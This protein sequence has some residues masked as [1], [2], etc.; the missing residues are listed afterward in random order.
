MQKEFSVKIVPAGIT[1]G[2][3]QGPEKLE[4]GLVLENGLEKT[5]KHIPFVVLRLGKLEKVYF[6]HKA[7]LNKIS[8]PV[9]PDL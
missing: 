5:E 9:F 6:G 1:A 8:L 3:P 4:K 2:C 7:C